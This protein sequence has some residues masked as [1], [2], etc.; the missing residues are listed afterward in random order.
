MPDF[1]DMQAMSFSDDEDEKH[2]TLNFISDMILHTKKNEKV[3]FIMQRIRVKKIIVEHLLDH[4]QRHMILK[5]KNILQAF[6]NEKL[7]ELIDNKSHL[8][9]VL[10]HRADRMQSLPRE[11]FELMPKEVVGPLFDNEEFLNEVKKELRRAEI[12]RKQSD[13][14]F[15][16]EQ[17]T[18]TGQ[19]G[20]IKEIM[21]N[22]NQSQRNI[23]MNF[24]SYKSGNAIRCKNQN[25]ISKRNESSLSKQ[26]HHHHHHHSRNKRDNIAEVSIL[27]IL[28]KFF[29]NLIKNTNKIIIGF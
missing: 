14:D 7:M 26:H 23:Q 24:N 19:I 25:S 10:E 21:K 12:M 5:N 22:L 28:S 27:Y 29:E 17:K 13:L 11:Q 16:I 8:P 15:G 6:V 2:N 1:G 3:S 20:E 4:N 18:E 9:M